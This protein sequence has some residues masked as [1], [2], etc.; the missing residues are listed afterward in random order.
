MPWER[1]YVFYASRLWSF[2]LLGVL[3]FAPLT[4]TFAAD[5]TVNCPADSFQTTLDSLGGQPSTI[6]VHGDCNETPSVNNFDN[7][8]IQGDGTSSLGGL[9]VFGSRNMRIQS[10]TFRG[11]V[12]TDLQSSWI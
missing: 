5:V 11:Q 3:L 9:L 6:T 12:V 4:T 8:N 10:L 7:L 1:D 2:P